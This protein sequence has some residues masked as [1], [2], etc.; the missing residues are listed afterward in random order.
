MQ[1]IEDNY[2]KYNGT[3]GYPLIFDLLNFKGSSCSYG[4]AYY[5]CMKWG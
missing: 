5:T 1:Q 2:D 4:T 3:I